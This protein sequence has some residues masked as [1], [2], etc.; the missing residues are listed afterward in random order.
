MAEEE[1]GVE[2]EESSWT[3]YIEGFMC[4]AGSDIDESTA[5]PSLV[6]DAA[7]SAVVKKINRRASH[8]EMGSLGFSN[9]PNN[10]TAHHHHHHHLCKQ[11]SFKKQKTKVIPAPNMDFDLEDTA[12][13]PVNSPKQVSSYMND[14]F[15]MNQ[16][17][18]GKIVEYVSELKRNSFA[19]GSGGGV[20][21]VERD[22]HA[23]AH[24]AAN[25]AD[26][27]KRTTSTP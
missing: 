7:S 18:K 6:S 14:Q 16:K 23:H 3:F 26:F 8:V 24:A 25:Y 21:A 17:G 10:K 15:M 13:S 19:K 2:G 27:K 12:S 9:S 11:S 5:T 1:Y 22:A 20:F 4:D